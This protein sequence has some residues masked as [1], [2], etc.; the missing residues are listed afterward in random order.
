MAKKYPKLLHFGIDYLRLNF[1]PDFRSIFFDDLFSGLSTNSSFKKVNFFGAE[2]SV[3]YRGTENLKILEFHFGQHQAFFLEKTIDCGLARF[4]SY[5]LEFY[6]TFFYIDEIK[7]LLPKICKTFAKHL[8]ISRVDLALDIVSNMRELRKAGYNSQFRKSQ[9]MGIDESSGDCETW[10]LGSKTKSNKK[11]FLRVYDKLLDSQKKSKIA[12]FKPLFKFD[13]VLRI[14][15][16]IRSQS[17]QNF[18]ITP[19]KIFDKDFLQSVFASV[20]INKS[21]THLKLLKNIFRQK[22][23]ILKLKKSEESEI[24][25]KLPYAKVM[26]GYVRNLEEMGF[27]TLE[28]LTNHVYSQ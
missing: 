9:K 27:D 23:I 5:K 3:F 24:L 2:F 22:P 18:R 15:A 1:S 6:S 17:C 28:F 12:I 10:Y 7:E 11:H 4:R 19:E 25:E 14:E 20:A 8:S 26:A 21:G 16:E 13:E